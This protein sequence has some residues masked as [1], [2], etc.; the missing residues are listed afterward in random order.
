MA[1]KGIGEKPEE[2]EVKIDFKPTHKVKFAHN[3][4]KVGDKI[5]V[6]DT[7]SEEGKN[8]TLIAKTDAKTAIAVHG[9]HIEKL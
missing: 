9:R 1:K 8:I 5:Q 4:L 6:L 7:H 2:T 3:G